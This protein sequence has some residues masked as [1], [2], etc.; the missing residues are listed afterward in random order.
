MEKSV[1]FGYT[2]RKRGSVLREDSSVE[3]TCDGPQENRDQGR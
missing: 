1:R 2:A 3:E